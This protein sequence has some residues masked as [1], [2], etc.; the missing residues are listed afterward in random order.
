MNKLKNLS[1]ISKLIINASI[2]VLIIFIMGYIGYSSVGKSGDIKDQLYNEG[3]M[4]IKDLSTID[5]AL[6]NIRLTIRN[7]MVVTEKSERE[8]SKKISDEYADIFMKTWESYSK[9]AKSKEE[10]E[11]AKKTEELMKSYIS[12]VTDA[13]NML[14]AFDDV[15]VRNLFNGIGT[16]TGKAV[17]E[18][19]KSLIKLNYEKANEVNR[20]AEEHQSSTEKSFIWFIIIG[21]VISV[22]G[23]IIISK[24]INSKFIWYEAMLDS[25]KYP[26]TVTDINGNWTFV[27]KSV[28]DML[29]KKRGDLVG[30]S[31]SEWGA[32]ICKTKNCGIEKLRNGQPVTFFEQGGGYYKV[33][34][35]YIKDKKG[36]NIGHIE[37]V[38]DITDLKKQ[39]DLI[40]DAANTMLKIS[41]DVTDSAAELQMSTNSAASSSE[42]ISSNSSSVATSSEE[43]ASS[44][45]EIASNTQQAFQISSEAAKKA[46]VASS[47][48]DKL[49]QS[50]SDVAKIVKIIT[51]IAEQTNLLAL[52]ATIE[53]ARAGESG[54][55][56]AVVANEVKELAKQSAKATE[57]ITNNI[58]TSIKD[59]EDTIGIINEING[60]IKDVNNITNSIASA[61][62]EQ[63]VTVSEITRNLNEVTSGSGTIAK[64]N[65]EIASTATEYSNMAENLNETASKLKDLSNKLQKNLTV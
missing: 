36:I 7:S 37:F 58:Q 45:K 21:L 3:L 4:P 62:E 30:R 38:T 16:Q 9:Y 40:T 14:I 47:S 53:A 49:S 33:D 6:L 27:N 63:S 64:V 46:D 25:V 59:T 55:G 50:S 54:K 18:S 61:I 1:V 44:I 41:R 52:N 35:S 24:S 51:G 20:V 39:T 5:D 10:A 48:M 31:C 42:Q 17:G 8:K 60:I 34:T 28:E 32:A 22:A 57:E 56:F 15:G 12:I 65:A 13:H 2:S 26:M 43:M 11:L 23:S 19:M 29:N